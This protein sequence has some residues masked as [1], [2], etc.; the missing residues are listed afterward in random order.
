M[1][2]IENN[3]IAIEPYSFQLGVIAA[4]AEMVGG[5]VKQLALSHPLIPM[6]ADHILQTAEDIVSRN[7]AQLYRE[8]E[9]IITDLFPAEVAIGKHV[10][11]IHTGASLEQYLALKAQKEAL[12]QNGTYGGDKRR[13]IAIAFGKLL[14]YPNERIHQLLSQ[15]THE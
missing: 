11:L 15:N 8:V 2:K 12:L 1:T 13:E 5:G 14:S 7:G 3:G 6:E 9:L 10:L 4:F